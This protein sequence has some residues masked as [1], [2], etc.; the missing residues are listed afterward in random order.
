MKGKDG[1]IYLKQGG[2]GRLPLESDDWAEMLCWKLTRQR[3]ERKDFQEREQSLQRPCNKSKQDSLGSH[4]C[5]NSLQSDFLLYCANKTIPVKVT[6][7]LLVTKSLGHFLSLSYLI[8]TPSF[9]KPPSTCLPIHST[10]MVF[11]L[12]LKL[13][14]CKFFFFFSIYK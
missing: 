8:Y 2:E 11:L 5:F 6:R 7:A 3:W 13:L 10:L 14:F 9:M 1:R 4:L 12:L